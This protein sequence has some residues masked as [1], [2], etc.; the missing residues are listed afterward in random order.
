MLDRNSSS[1]TDVS[2]PEHLDKREV[3][4]RSLRTVGTSGDMRCLNLA[5]SVLD[6]SSCARSLTSAVFTNKIYS[7]KNF[8]ILNIDWH[9]FIYRAFPTTKKYIGHV[10]LGPTIVNAR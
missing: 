9:Y 5:I 2:A 3:M 8:R 6:S 1:G 4:E 10:F 7:V